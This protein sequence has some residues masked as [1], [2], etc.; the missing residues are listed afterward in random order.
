[1]MHYVT[2]ANE[3]GYAMGFNCFIYNLAP[4]SYGQAL[5]KIFGFGI[6]TLS[7]APK[8]TMENVPQHVDIKEFS[9]AL[10]QKNNG[11]YEDACEHMHT[12]CVLLPKVDKFKVDAASGKLFGSNIY[13][14]LTPSSAVYGAN[15]GEFDPDQARLIWST[16][17]VSKAEY[18]LHHRAANVCGAEDECDNMKQTREGERFG[19][20][21][22][23]VGW[24][25][26]GIVVVNQRRNAVLPAYEKPYKDSDEKH[27][28]AYI[29]SYARFLW[30]LLVRGCGNLASPEQTA[31][32]KDMSNPLYGCDGLPK[33]VRVF[34]FTLDS[35]S[36]KLDWFLLHQDWKLLFFD[37][38][39]SFDSAVH[40]VHAV[41]FDAAVFNVADTVSAAAGS[42]CI[43]WGGLL[44]IIEKDQ[45][46]FLLLE[47]FVSADGTKWFLLAVQVAF[48]L[49]M[50]LLVMFSFLLTDIESADLNYRHPIKLRPYRAA[51][52]YGAEDECDIMKQTRE[53]ERF[54]NC[55]RCV[56]WERIG[57]VVVNQRRNAVLP[58]Y[59]K[60]YKDSDE[61]HLIAYI[62][63]YARFLSC[64]LVR[65]CGNSFSMLEPELF[66]DV[67]QW[68][69]EKKAK[70]ASE[71]ESEPILH[72]GV[73]NLN[74]V[75]PDH[76][77]RGVEPGQSSQTTMAPQITNYDLLFD[78][79]DLL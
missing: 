36:E 4:R 56:G 59:E 48:L 65:G 5:V 58:A 42:P 71:T 13:M 55:Y 7:S 45:V 29:F 14:N 31:T 39:T 37:V 76:A 17:M 47:M 1:M 16:V 32:G 73:H 6:D 70:S 75:D 33:T 38:A 57:I 52:V 69:T 35:C 22:R 50:F 2:V 74:G 34:Q 78:L 20:C 30:C 77:S 23:C 46:S 61:K 41:S 15:E 60:P 27:L 53:G 63:C 12:C 40:R 24:E 67:Y 18:L 44:G 51:N 62:F 8:L 21:Y 28:I 11:E 3:K 68:Q 19:N 64:L 72:S 25:R 43:C 49:I 26:I 79:Y 9:E 66:T 54:G 10:A